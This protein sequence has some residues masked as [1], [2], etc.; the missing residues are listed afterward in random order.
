MPKIAVYRFVCCD[1]ESG[2]NVESP[3]FAT[4]KAIKLRDGR[5]VED[6]RRIVDDCDVDENG[7]LKNS[8]M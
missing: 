5:N 4:L 7:F 1:K 3:R 8:K 6:S 2:E